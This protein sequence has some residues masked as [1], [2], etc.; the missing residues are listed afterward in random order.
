MVRVPAFRY[1]GI[2]LTRFKEQY[3]PSTSDVRFWCRTYL[4]HMQS[5][6]CKE[7]TRRPSITRTRTTKNTIGSVSFTAV[8]EE[9]PCRDTRR[10]G[11]YQNGRRGSLRQLH[12]PTFGPHIAV[13][14][15]GFAIRIPFGISARI[16]RN[17]QGNVGRWAIV[18]VVG[19]CVVVDG[20]GCGSGCGS[21]C[22]GCWRVLSCGMLW[23][24]VV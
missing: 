5:Y 22:G 10:K 3:T 21:G 17:R 23:C 24:M 7:I 9:T 13:V 1:G 4:P 8:S 11:S 18:C 14:K 15:D 16:G 20:R 12:R 2:L 19:G 6:H